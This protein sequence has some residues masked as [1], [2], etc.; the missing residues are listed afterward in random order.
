MQ[1]DPDHVAPWVEAVP[2]RRERKAGSSDDRQ[3]GRAARADHDLCRAGPVAA[4]RQMGARN[5]HRRYAAFPA[6]AHP[7][8]D[9]GEE[10]GAGRPDVRTGQP[11]VVLGAAEVEQG[12]ERA[13]S[14]PPLRRRAYDRACRR[15]FPADREL[16][17]GGRRRDE[18]SR[19]SRALLE[20]R[21]D[22][23]IAGGVDWKLC[24][25][26]RPDRGRPRRSHLGGAGRGAPVEL[27]GDLRRAI[28]ATSGRRRFRSRPERMPLVAGVV[29][30]RRVEHVVVGADRTSAGDLGA[31]LL[32]QR[33]PAL[34]GRRPAPLPPARRRPSGPL[35]SA[36]T[37][38]STVRRRELTV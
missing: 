16:A 2:A 36:R 20:A 11:D 4:R 8:P 28:A 6:T 26:T 34:N 23:G 10:A 22:S 13:D 31:T 25:Y 35:P 30:R 19:P 3:H 27:I 9:P 24:A 1:G 17:G 33:E 21:G 12:V 7:G 38:R 37:V 18:P 14:R 5:A 32:A 29:G 15:A